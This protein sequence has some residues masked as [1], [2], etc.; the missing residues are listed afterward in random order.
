ML[1]P[2]TLPPPVREFLHDGLRLLIARLATLTEDFRAGLITAIGRTLADGAEHL[3]DRVIPQGG[4]SRF[5]MSENRGD[6]YAETGSTFKDSALEFRPAQEFH[7]AP[8]ADSRTPTP[9]SRALVAA[10]LNALG[11]WLLRIGLVPCSAV[12]AMLGGMVLMFRRSN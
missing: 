8:S 12:V 2:L 5:Q 1:I 7:E 4:Q 9:L 10:G 11:V 3:M 6:S